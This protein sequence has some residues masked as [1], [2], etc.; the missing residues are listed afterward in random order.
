MKFS[1]LSQQDKMLL[2]T[3]FSEGLEKAA[4]EEVNIFNQMYTMGYEKLASETADSLDKL[5]AEKDEEEEEK[6]ELDEESEKKAAELGAIIERGFFDGLC[7]L[8][9]DRHGDEMHYLA[10]FVQEKMAGWRDN[11]AKGQK[12]VSDFGAKLKGHAE[13]G[14]QAVKDYHKGIG[15]HARAAMQGSKSMQGAH[16]GKREMLI[17][18]GERAM[19]A[20][21][22]LGKSTPHLAVAGGGGYLAYK[23]LKKKDQDKE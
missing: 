15:E 9:Q 20:G 16:G 10:P 17:G 8:G 14:T 23:G 11:L 12:S 1:E 6:E 18:A 4:A 7:K 21:K 5:A 13:K 22:A 2:N 19:E 3:D